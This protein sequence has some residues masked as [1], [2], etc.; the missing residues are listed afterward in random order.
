MDKIAKYIEQKIG[1]EVHLER[2]NLGRWAIPEE[3]LKTTNIRF[4]Q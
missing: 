4:D 1:H 2:D 3:L